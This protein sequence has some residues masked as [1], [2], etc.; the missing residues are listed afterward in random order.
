M[1]CSDAGGLVS[2]ITAL[3]TSGPVGESARTSIVPP[4]PRELVLI[5]IAPTLAQVVVL[6]T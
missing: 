1:R 6:G 5:V 2:G 3:A 4:G